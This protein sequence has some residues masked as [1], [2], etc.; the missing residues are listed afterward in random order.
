MM[1]HSQKCV[2][3]HQLIKICFNIF[4]PHFFANNLKNVSY[5]EMSPSR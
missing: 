3:D 1:H 2:I 5:N 4:K